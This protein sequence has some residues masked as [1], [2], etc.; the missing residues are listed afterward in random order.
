MNRIIIRWNVGWVN[1]IEKGDKTGPTAL[2]IE[3]IA[4]SFPMA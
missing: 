3:S 4:D 1:A 2:G